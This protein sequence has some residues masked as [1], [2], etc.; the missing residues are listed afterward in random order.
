ME[1]DHTSISNLSPGP[2]V[3]HCTVKIIS[4]QASND[5][6]MDQQIITPSS[7]INAV[8]NKEYKC[9]V[10]VKEREDSNVIHV[11]DDNKVG[12]IYDLSKCGDGHTH[13]SQTNIAI[14]FD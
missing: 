9:T 3:Y 6:K 2:G 4:S 5:I 13:D 14:D 11:I 7:C 8:G 10:V 12:L 1:I